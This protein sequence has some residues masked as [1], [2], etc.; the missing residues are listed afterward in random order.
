M[1]A[2]GL[3]YVG[4]DSNGAVARLLHFAVSDVDDSVRRAAALSL[5]FLLLRCPA[6]C[7]RIVALLAESYSPHLR[8][9]AA[10]A[11]GIACAGTGALLL[12]GLRWVERRVC[13]PGGVLTP[14]HLI[15]TSTQA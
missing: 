1:Y 6:Q 5:G 4:T 14:S 3:A 12:R 11:V 15:S 7:P 8:Y 10:M 9:G 13:V 2:L